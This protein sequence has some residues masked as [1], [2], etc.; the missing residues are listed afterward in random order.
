MYQIVNVATLWG[1]A[2]IGGLVSQNAAGF[3]LQFRI[4]AFFQALSIPLLIFGAPETMF[5]RS[6]NPYD[7]PTTAGWTPGTGLSSLLLTSASRRFRRLPTRA[8]GSGMLLNRIAQYIDSVTPPHSYS[9]GKGGTRDIPLLLQAPRALIAPTTVLAFLAS[10]LPYTLLWGYSASLSG[11]FAPDPFDLYPAT[12]GSL[13]ATPFILATAAAAVF[14]LWPEWSR[15]HNAF[16]PRSSHLFVLGAG[17]MLSLIGAIAFS[18]YVAT[19]M[20]RTSSSGSG[21]RFS[22]LSFIFGLLAAGAYILDAPSEPLIRRSAQFTAPNLPRSLRNAADMAAGLAIWKA[23]F[24]GIFSMGIPAAVVSGSTGI[25]STGIGIGV[26]QIFV[27]AG[28]GVVW[29]MRDESVRRMD[30]RVMRCVDLE[31]LRRMTTLTSIF[32][33]EE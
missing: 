7:Q 22:A 20:D 33:M 23:L 1:P 14:A 2:L 26:V 32:E 5:E 12:V 8:P 21:I 15:T 4:L 24:A 25:K 9:G 27:A 19:Q 17:A 31:S 16:R 11:L 18:Q 10:F 28:V 3:T 30:G 13:L 29:Y 6:P